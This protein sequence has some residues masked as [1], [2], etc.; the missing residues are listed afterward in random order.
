MKKFKLAASV[1]L[2]GARSAGFDY[3]G[4]TP[5]GSLWGMPSPDAFRFT[6][7]TAALMAFRADLRDRG[8]SAGTVRVFAPGGERYADHVLGSGAFYFGSLEWKSALP[9]VTLSA[10]E[11]CNA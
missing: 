2:Y 3:L 7:V 1:C 11:V 5:D 4:E 9:A 6:S 8:I 10:E